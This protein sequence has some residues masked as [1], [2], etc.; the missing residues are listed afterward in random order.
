MGQRAD[1]LAGRRLEGDDET[2]A[3]RH[4]IEQ[5]RADMTNT[6]DAIQDKLDPEMLSEQAKDTAHDVTDYAI[7]EAKE[8]AREVTEH[9]LEQAKAAVREV[10]LQAKTAVRDATIGKVENM[11]RTAT[12]TAGDWRQTLTSTVR[13]NPL[14]AAAAGLSL[15]WL[16]F[17][18]SSSAPKRYRST[19]GTTGY[20]TYESE[21]PSTLETATD[22]AREKVGRVADQAATAAGD[23]IGRAQD[24]TAQVVGQVQDTGAQMVEGV[25]E[26]AWRAQNFVQ[27]QLEE[28]PLLV[29]A[30]A[31]VV[32]GV[33]AGTVRSTAHEDRLFGT[34]RD[35]LM[36]NAKDLTDETVQKVGQVVDEAKTAAKQEAQEQKLVAQA[37]ADKN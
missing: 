15:L 35:R 22:D 20:D 28:N 32:G 11:A 10:T 9:A 27:R 23:V 8:A 1:Q 17:N 5:T 36:G 14:P 12:D 26:Q 24:T 2:A 31:A 29:G 25:Q 33:L 34:T 13:E 18:R 37:E 7:R 3:A 16:Y 6:I 4:E 30:V 21:E 19:Y